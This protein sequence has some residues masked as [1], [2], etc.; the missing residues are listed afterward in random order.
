MNQEIYYKAKGKSV[1]KKD[2]KT[3]PTKKE[4]I[5]LDYTY[6]EYQ[7]NNDQPNVEEQYY[8]IIMPEIEIESPLKD[9]N[10]KTESICD[11][12]MEVEFEIEMHESVKELKDQI[13]RESIQK[14]PNLCTIC[15]RSYADTYYF[16]KH[17]QSHALGTIK[18]ENKRTPG[19]NPRRPRIGPQKFTCDLCGTTKNDKC[20]L[21]E[22]IET[23]HMK[24]KNAT[25][26]ICG[27][28]FHTTTI[29]SHMKKMHDLE[30]KREKCEICNKYFLDLKQ[31][32]ARNHNYNGEYPCTKCVKIFKNRMQ[33]GM[34]MSKRHPAPG[35]FQCTICGKHLTNSNGLKEHMHACHYGGFLY[36]CEW[37]N[38]YRGNH[39][40]NLLS[41]YR[42]AH[43]LE[44][45]VRQEKIQTMHD[46]PEIP[47]ID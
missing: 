1:I 28:K 14:T 7:S 32:H 4:N 34:H 38:S 24:L 26:H 9:V 5:P 45:K 16:K 18:R 39:K 19:P 27:G 43:P 13:K 20:R 30:R 41:H 42:K 44:Y 11:N 12:L 37:C 46:T 3:S 31:H 33:L 35:K 8:D 6:D 21:R 17:L 25:C 22:H 2:E 23:I 40:R 15:G 36:Q 29:Q 10:I 47:V